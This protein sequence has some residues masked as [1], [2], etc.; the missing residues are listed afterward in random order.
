MRTRRVV[1]S[2][3]ILRA[4][5]AGVV[6]AV[7][8]VGAVTAG[9]ATVLPLYDGLNYSATGNPP[10]GTSNSNNAGSP[11]QWL[12]QGNNTVEPRIFSGSLTYPGLPPSVGNKVQLDTTT[13]TGADASRL[14]IGT[15]NKTD[16]PTLYYSYVLNV[17]TSNA[18]ASPFFAGFDNSTNTTY[19]QFGATYIQ[20]DLSDG[21]KF[22][23]GIGFA[24]N[25]NFTTGLTPGTTLFV[26]GSYTFQGIANLDVFTA[27][28]AVPTAEPAPGTHTVSS[29]GVDATTNNVI[30]KFFV[31]GNSGEMNGIQ[32]DEVRIGTTWA[33]VAAKGYYWDI[34]GADPGS[35]GATPS[36]TWDGVAT[37]FTSDPTG[38][39]GTL[40]ATATRGDTMIFSAGSDATGSYTV[41]VSG[42]QKA[43]AVNVKN[44]N[45]TF[46]GG[47]ALTVGRFEIPAGSSATV[48]STVNGGETNGAVLKSG[49]G[50]VTFSAANTYAGGTTIAGGGMGIGID[51][52]GAGAGVTSG[53]LGTGAITVIS[54]AAGVAPFLFA[55][56][57]PRTL[58]NNIVFAGSPLAIGGSNDLTLAG[59]LALG[60]GNRGLRID[61]GQTNFTGVISGTT[62]IVKTGTGAAV[63]SG[64]NTYSGA[65]SIFA[66]VL[67]V[68]SSANLGDASGTNGILLNG[69][70]LRATGPVS[71]PSRSVTLSVNSTIDAGAS[72]ALGDVSG[73]AGLTKTGSGTLTI[74]SFRAPNLT[75]N[76]G[77]LQLAPNGQ[78]TGVSVLNTLTIAGGQLDIS[79][80]HL[81]DHTDGVAV[82]TAKIAPGRNGGAWNGSGIVT[83]QTTATTSSLTSIGIA[84]AQQAKT[85]AT[86]SD[87]AVW[88]GQTVTGSDALVMYTYGGDANL[89]GQINVDDY[90]RIDLNIPLGTSGWFN[91]DFNYDGKID[92]DDY[93]II[94]FNVG[95]QGAPFFSAG[96]AGGPSVNAV[97]EPTACLLLAPA[98]ALFMRRGRRRNSL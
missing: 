84:S 43:G 94:D 95:I 87:T 77:R 4:A 6:T 34:N 32:I 2:R 60:N 75:V 44:G 78:A 51:S 10:L 7:P 65:T 29:P 49:D 68:S 40:T 45:V 54:P 86:A 83:S 85:L 27:P 57:G 97:P 25:R 5:T 53:A 69:G 56:G 62:G 70:T 24:G 13:P 89:D 50:N 52:V 91:G 92:V 26:V 38:G 42:T 14:Y 59:D 72:I 90:G 28:A 16:V 80:N 21:T 55:D 71:S 3:N 76:A 33:D 9:A 30:S 96:G 74:N 63:L 22:D 36:G 64:T 61:N 82:L 19:H 31:R 81:I 98:A 23:L 58:G 39:A 73:T 88:A 48:S 15:I 46:S 67:S 79:D 11:G 41:T 47:G 17:P 1:Y 66:G 93:G 37:N 8:L 20:K 12:F 35:N 18:T